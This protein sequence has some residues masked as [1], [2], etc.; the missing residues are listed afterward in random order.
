MSDTLAAVLRAEPDWDALPVQEHPTLCR[1]IE[2]CLERNPKQ[3]LRDIG[4]ARIFLEDGGSEQSSLSFSHLDL[5]A[6]AAGTAR[7][8][9]PLALLALVAVACLAAGAL[10][11]RQLLASTDTPRVLHTM[12]PPP[13]RTEYDLRDSAPG[14]A[15]LSPDGTMIVFGAFDEDGASRLY[16]RHL[17]RG[18][19][20]AL[21]GTGSAAYP[22]WS[23]DSRFIGFFDME[24][25]KLR[26]VAVAGGPPVSLC[27]AENGKG[28]SWNRQGDII[29]APAANN[30]IFRV[31][32][33]GGEAVRI[34]EI[35]SDH[36]S[37]RHPR[38]LPDG[39]HFIFTA[40]VN[41]AG[42]PNDVYLASLD[43]TFTP[44]IIAQTQANADYVDGELLTVREGV[45]V[46]TPFTPDQE[47][48]T[49]SGAPLVEDILVL[50]G[51]AVAS[52]SPSPTGMFVYQ[53]GSSAM[54][55]KQLYWIELDGGDQEA[56]GDTGQLFHPVISPD[57][58]Q[59]VMEVRGASNEGTDLWLVDLT[60]GLRTRFTFAPGDEYRP[61]WSRDGQFIYYASKQDGGYRILQQPVEGQGG[62][63]IVLEAAEEILPT[64]VSPGDRELLLNHDRDGRYVEMQRL[65]LSSNEAELTTLVAMDE[66]NVGGG[67]YSPDGRWIAYHAE[68]ASGFDVFV[69]PAGGGAR[70]WQ[71]TSDGA[72]FP[73]WT[74][75]GE[76]LWVSNFNGDL[77]VYEVDGSGDTFRVGS[78]RPSV[79]V[80]PPD[81]TGC[82]YDL[83][84]DG[85]RLLTSGNEATF[86][87]DISYLH[88]VTDWRRAL[89]Q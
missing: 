27:P 46:A 89:V 49:E 22:F 28:G 54:T 73:H 21:S 74:P 88:L 83:H 37:H 80:T 15:A 30:E 29:F 85:L 67:I 56:L 6:D 17:D 23:P 78:Y 19:S 31:P 34:T 25:G 61:V 41:A 26:K 60:T 13:E 45:L 1:L 7:S 81:A 2:R 86:S 59:A 8:R 58:S 43:T 51:A 66:A 35:G 72:V 38:F 52:F 33:I 68:S 76:H 82:Y 42:R 32:D 64:S 40:R 77:R 50:P 14:P 10:V 55:T 53:T 16:L 39:E 63:A 44:R 36:N 5:G 24:N 57:G 62:A 87:A 18:E 47:R 3:R 65:D 48:V 20:V 71:V 79:T 11:G 9:P 70:K 84:P 12:V 69:M 75:D 4:E